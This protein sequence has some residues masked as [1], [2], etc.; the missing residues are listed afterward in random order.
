M[1]KPEDFEHQLR[2][3]E[4]DR[5][6]GAS[7]L[8]R[9]GLEILAGSALYGRAGSAHELRELLRHRARVLAAARPSMA[10]LHNLL[11]RWQ[12]TLAELGTEELGRFRHGAAQ[13]ASALVAASKR[14]VREAAVH[15]C[16][17]LAQNPTIITHSLSSTL[18]E[19][20]R[21]HTGRGLRAILTESRPLNEGYSLAAELSNRGIATR[22]ITESQVGLFVKEADVAMVGADSLLPDG[23]VLNKAGTYLLA[24]AARDQGV[25][26]YVSCESFKLRTPQMGKVELEE[27]DPAELNAPDLPHVE[28]RNVYFD[29]TPASL[30]TGWITERGLIRRWTGRL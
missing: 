16:D 10:P 2:A 1:Q 3:L 11:E 9:Q 8:A 6:H 27:M 5:V 24:L 12:C 19:V 30:I 23:S 22:L 14:A 26:F 25:P 15:A 7:E 13:A 29:I 4:Q 28:V 18:L 20:F 21:Q 17:Q